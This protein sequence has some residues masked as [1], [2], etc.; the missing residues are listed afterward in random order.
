[1]AESGALPGWLNRLW[2]VLLPG[3]LFV[4]AISFALLLGAIKWEATGGGA[5]IGR[6]G[7][8]AHVLLVSWLLVSL[9]LMHLWLLVAA[10]CTV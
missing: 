10:A 4:A 9:A 1:M 7:V 8:S 6:M 3:V 5:V 2:W